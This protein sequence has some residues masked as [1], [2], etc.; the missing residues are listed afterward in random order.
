M[1]EKEIKDKCD[2]HIKFSKSKAHF[3]IADP[4]S[5]IGDN[6]ISDADAHNFLKL[7]RAERQAYVFL[8][9]FLKSYYKESPLRE[10]ENLTID[11]IVDRSEDSDYS[12]RKIE[13]KFTNGKNLLIWAETEND[14]VPKLNF[15]IEN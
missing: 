5:L 2:E 13:I 9:T 12:E 4:Q 11:K 14:D 3:Y 8:A 10:L 15:T 7:Y 1:T 6:E